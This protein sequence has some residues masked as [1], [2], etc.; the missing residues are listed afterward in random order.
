MRRSV[1]E[2][3][4][5]AVMRL[6]VEDLAAMEAMEETAARLARRYRWQFRTQRRQSP[7]F[8][9]TT[10]APAEPV[11]RAVPGSQVRRSAVPAARVEMLFSIAGPLSI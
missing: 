11:A 4:D 10:V 1:E 3:A 8:K 6:A 5:A 7:R 2:A 9:R